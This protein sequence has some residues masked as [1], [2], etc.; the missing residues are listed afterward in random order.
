MHQ[1]TILKESAVERRWFHASAKGKV[2]GPLAVAVAETLMGRTKR[3]YTP[4]VDAGDFVVVTDVEGLVFTGNKAAR[5]LYSFHTGYFGGLTEIPLGTLHA[6]NP[7][8]LFELAVRRML[9]K[10]VQSKHMMKRLKV[11]KGAAH[12]HACQKP[13]ALPA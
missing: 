3:T 10:T 13:A 5:K 1:T 2:L 9:P 7:E 4:H 11:Y 8:R 12:P 6:R